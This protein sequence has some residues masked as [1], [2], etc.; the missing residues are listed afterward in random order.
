MFVIGNARRKMTMT[1]ARKWW[2]DT[3]LTILVCKK[4][5]STGTVT[6]Y[7]LGSGVNYDYNSGK[8]ENF[9]VDNGKGHTT[10]GMVEI[11]GIVECCGARILP[12]G[13]YM[14]DDKLPVWVFK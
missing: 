1:E 3:P 11:I 12:L 5:T 4:T 6:I 8:M 7:I 9:V 10:R 2:G 13:G 14:Q